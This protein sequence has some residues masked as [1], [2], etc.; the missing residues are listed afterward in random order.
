MLLA[1]EEAGHCAPR[2]GPKRSDCFDT[3]ARSLQPCDA[4]AI[5]ARIGITD[6][7]DHAPDARLCEQVGAARATGRFMRARLQAD[8]SR[9][10]TRS[11]ASHGEGHRLGMRPPLRLSP[12][13]PDNP[14]C[15]IQ[16]DAS[17][18]GI[19]RRAPPRPLGKR[20]GGLQPDRI[21]RQGQGV[22]VAALSAAPPSFSRAAASFCSS[23]FS[24]A[25]KSSLRSRSLRAASSRQSMP[26]LSARR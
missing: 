23:S 10:A 18:I 19:G 20:D 8:I 22:V 24:F 16:Q 14:A 12:A 6:G 1:H 11:I 17:D 25:A 21:G 26:R 5:G 7:N 3:D 9:A 2:L 13:A 15:G 4:R